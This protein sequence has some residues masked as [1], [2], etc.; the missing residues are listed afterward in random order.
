MKHLV[1]NNRT[2]AKDPRGLHIVDELQ[3]PLVGEGR[4][5]RMVPFA[6]TATLS[7][8]IAVP[9]TSWTK[10]GLA[11]VAHVLLISAIVGAML[12][13]WHRIAR[14]AQL[15]PV[16]L[17]LIA[18]VMLTIATGDGI[19]SPFVSL[20][21]LPLMW[22]AIYEHRVA[23]VVAAVLAGAGLSIAQPA[24]DSVLSTNG[25]LTTTVF[26]VV[27][28]G[29]GITLHGVVADAR[30]VT[31]ALGGQQFALEQSAAVL[32]ALPER[33]SRY[34]ISDH[35]VTY[36]NPAW[37][38]LYG[39]DPVGRVLDEFL[40]A[41]EVVGLRS[42]LELL[43][44][45]SPILVDT[46][47]RATPGP[48]PRWLEWV[49][50]YVIGADG[51]EILSIGRDVTLRHH[52]EMQLAESEKRFRELAD[53]SADVVWRIS[54][55]PTPHFDYIS[56][57][58]ERIIGYPPSYFLEDFKHILNILDAEGIKTIAQALNGERLPDHFD[59]RF[60]HA[61][62]SVVI[63]ETRSAFVSGGLQGVSRDVTELRRLQ[64]EMEALAL[65]DPLTGLANRRLFNE[66]LEADL[67]RSQ[68]SNLPLAVAFLD[69]DG[70]KNVN[71]VYGHDAGD[72]V[73]REVGRRL[74]KM[75]R[76]ADTVARLGGDEFVIVY[77]PNDANS[78]NLIAR[79]DRSLS[80][81]IWITASTPVFCP[82][83]VGVADTTVVGYDRTA[84]LA[85][86][87][88]AM[89]E[90]KRARRAVRA[91]LAHT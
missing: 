63:G 56:P 6:V 80:E 85:A 46:S 21:V 69:L 50:R 37:A 68:R 78:F 47:P 23:V 15:L 43:S 91:D 33:V 45:E 89:Y 77:A 3:G 58:T 26:I 25:T 36:C 10:P 64:A 48:D 14:H 13:P 8:A 52:A 9:T 65:R 49:D 2:T 32:D 38:S 87:D 41:D 82:A 60:R 75:V 57:S 73:L 31:R 11:L 20:S 55:E 24:D 1:D 51:P 61:D 19:G 4:F 70:F 62:G 79:L 18:T 44:P 81:P 67:A 90:T 84:L 5:R 34:R 42:Q 28:A 29:M 86:A 54:T 71:D 17:F 88:E 76:G 72:V 27:C 83:S 66:L 74:Q 22:L 53:K 39:V 40:S 7:V 35:V 16:F 30:R 12:V 59:F